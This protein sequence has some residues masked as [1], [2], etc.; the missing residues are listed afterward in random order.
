[1]IISLISFILDIV[2]LNITKY[3]HEVM[4]IFPMFTIVSLLSS[5]YFRKDKLINYFTLSLYFSLT[6]LFVYPIFFYLLELYIIR[7]DLKN[8]NIKNYLLKIMTSLIVFDSLFFLLTKIPRIT[9]YNISLLFNKIV[10]TLP[11][12]I[13]YSVI[14]FY[15][16]KVL[17]KNNKK[18]KLV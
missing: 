2:I 14:L 6:G 4:L 17:K 3:N 11:I 12:N 5:I 10:I 9:S 7:K 16:N 1:M 8:F 15:I 13:L 18:Y